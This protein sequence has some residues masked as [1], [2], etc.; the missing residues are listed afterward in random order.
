MN[1]R[2]DKKKVE[3]AQIAVISRMIRKTAFC[4]DNYNPPSAIIPCA[5]MFPGAYMHSITPRGTVANQTA[6]S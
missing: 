5:V 3:I 2:A 4:L 6:S 1:A